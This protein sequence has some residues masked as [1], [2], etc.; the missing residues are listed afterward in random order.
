MTVSPADGR[1]DLLQ[2]TPHDLDRGH[3]EDDA[4][5]VDGLVKAAGA[6]EFRL[7]RDA[8]KEQGVGVG[9][10][11]LPAQF[12]FVGPQEDIMAVGGQSAGQGCPPASCADDG[13]PLALTLHRC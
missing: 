13:Y 10:I 11:D 7:Q 6:D 4:S 3:H 8:G 5:A 2:N 12:L 1:G 9:C